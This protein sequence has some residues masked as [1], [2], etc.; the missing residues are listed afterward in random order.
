MRCTI[1]TGMCE[2][3]RLV[4]SKYA[5]ERKMDL[6]TGKRVINGCW[7]SASLGISIAH[8]LFLA[9]A[10]HVSQHALVPAC[11]M[12]FWILGSFVGTRVRNASRRWGGRWFVCTL[13]WFGGTSSLVP[14]R[15]SLDALP[16]ALLSIVTLA[17]VALL[18]GASSTAG[19]S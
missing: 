9:H 4:R 7:L 16:S 19:L 12:S 17:M 15:L 14:S 11:I 18:L 8:M 2:E 6:V 13:L 1:T 10:W 3:K 5:V